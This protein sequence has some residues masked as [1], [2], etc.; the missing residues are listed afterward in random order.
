MLRK[1]LILITTLL[2]SSNLFAAPDGARLYQRH[3]SACHGLNGEGGVG[4]PLALPSFQ[5]AVDDQFFFTT[6]RHGRPGRVMPSF[7]NLSDAQVKAIVSHIRTL[8]PS[9]AKTHKTQLKPGYGNPAHGKEL[10]AKYCAHCHGANG[11]GGLLPPARS[12]D[13]GPGAE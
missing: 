12:A 9:A 4:I 2:I 3:C 1:Y 7:K 6:I 11:E 8:A 5:A 10:F 13:H